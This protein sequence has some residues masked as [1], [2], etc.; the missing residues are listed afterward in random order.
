MA[1]RFSPGEHRHLLQIQEYL[2]R[3][4]ESGEQVRDWM[5]LADRYASLLSGRGVEQLQAGK[6]RA[7]VRRTY[8]IYK[9]DGLTTDMRII[10]KLTGET[11]GIV[12]IRPDPTDGWY[13]LIECEQTTDTV[14]Q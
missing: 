14:Q 11:F 13:Q 2:W 3:E 5:K 4:N 9:L 6:Y 8:K 12:D 1:R 7:T 10:V